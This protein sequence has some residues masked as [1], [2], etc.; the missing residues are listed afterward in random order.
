MDSGEQRK[1]TRDDYQGMYSFECSCG[2]RMATNGQRLNQA[3]FGGKAFKCPNHLY[4]TCNKSYSAALF[5][6]IADF[7]PPHIPA[8]LQ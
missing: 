7:T 8:G 6:K 3:I 4:G 1:M 5:Q 2:G